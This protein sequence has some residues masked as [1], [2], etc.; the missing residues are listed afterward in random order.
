MQNRGRMWDEITGKK[1][2]EDADRWM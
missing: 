2:W 1:L